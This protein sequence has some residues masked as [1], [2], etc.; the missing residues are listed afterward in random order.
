MKHQVV[1]EATSATLLKEKP[2]EQEFL[3]PGDTIALELVDDYYR[4][5][6]GY[7]YLG[8]TEEV[9]CLTLHAM[10]YKE[11]LSLFQERQSRPNQEYLKAN[12]RLFS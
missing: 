9:R 8:L 1:Q 5:Q 2:C 11:I 10:Q 3:G 6:S 4:R 7:S 12:F